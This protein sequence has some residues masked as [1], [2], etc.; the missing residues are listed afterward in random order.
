MG[1]SRGISPI[2]IDEN[3]TEN[4][5]I[6][7]SR[8]R[9]YPKAIEIKKKTAD[10][11][12]AQLLH[13]IVDSVSTNASYKDVVKIC[14]DAFVGIGRLSKPHHIKLKNDAKPVAYPTRRVPFAF[15]PQLKT[16]LDQE[17]PNATY[18]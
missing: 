1:D 11:Q 12:C 9:N 8:F 16:C 10:V 4:R 13:L 6:W 15:M 7:I 14:K 5:R 17:G 3:V 18:A 2:W